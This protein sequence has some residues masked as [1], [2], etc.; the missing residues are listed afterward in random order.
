[1]VVGLGNP[2]PEYEG[3]RHNLGFEVLDR[4]LEKAGGRW[5]RSWRA[6]ALA[7]KV[8][9]AGD[10]WVLVKP[11]TYMNRSGSAVQS[12]ARYYRVE[13]AKLLVVVDDVEL[14]L[15]RLRLRRKGSAGHHNGLKS[16]VEAL[17]TEEFARLRL[18]VGDKPDGG[19]MVDHVLSKFRAEERPQVDEAVNLAVEAALC[20][21]REG[22]EKA[23][24]RYN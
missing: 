1:M 17:G 9:L 16:V 2:G 8:R 14:P 20:M 12:L 19:E 22:I 3:T 21:Q 11:L 7:A 13:L 24:N 23:M 10:A 5:K 18:G 6:R 4:L 15:G